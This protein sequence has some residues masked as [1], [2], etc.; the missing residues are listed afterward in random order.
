MSTSH[1]HNWLGVNKSHAA[2]DNGCMH[3]LSC[4]CPW[5]FSW[6]RLFGDLCATMKASMIA[7]FHFI[8]RTI[9]DNSTLCRNNFRIVSLDGWAESSCSSSSSCL[10]SNWMTMS[11][12]ECARWIE[13]VQW[14]TD[15][16]NTYLKRVWRI[17]SCT[18]HAFTFQ[19]SQWHTVR[20]KNPTNKA[21]TLD[22]LHELSAQTSKDTIL[23]MLRHSVDLS[24]M[25]CKINAKWASN[26]LSAKNC[27][28]VKF[29]ATMIVALPQHQGYHDALID[30]V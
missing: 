11:L 6:W 18:M 9:D 30:D 7:S 29:R 3:G 10:T 5:S 15:W 12:L 16:R 4:P 17:W 14:T 19:S 25:V 2:I 21:K 26:R 27:L 20:N 1:A 13:M 22:E 23:K 8:L 24:S 28:R